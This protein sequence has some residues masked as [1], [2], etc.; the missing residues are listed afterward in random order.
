[1][2]KGSEVNKQICGYVW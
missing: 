1:V 2:L